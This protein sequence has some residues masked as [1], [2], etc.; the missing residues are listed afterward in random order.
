[1]SRRIT[2]PAGG[3]R[4]VVFTKMLVTLL[5]LEARSTGSGPVEYHGIA[6]SDTLHIPANP[7]PVTSASVSPHGASPPGTGSVVGT[8]TPSRSSPYAC[9]IGLWL[10]DF[11]FFDGRPALSIGDCCVTSQRHPF[12]FKGKA[13]PSPRKR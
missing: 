4:G 10:G 2:V 8:A 11:D 9:F 5:A 7:V 6:G 12:R 3:Y 13:R 1:M